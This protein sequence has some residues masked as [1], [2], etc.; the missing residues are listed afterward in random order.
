MARNRRNIRKRNKVVEL[1]TDRRFIVISSIL[2]VLILVLVGFFVISTH[3]KKAN[4]EKEQEQIKLQQQDIFELAN[5]DIDSV[6]DFESDSVIRLSVTG[7]IFCNDK[8]LQTTLI[9]ETYNFS[10]IFEDIEEYINDSNVTIGTLNTHFLD[11]KINGSNKSNSPKEFASK[12]KDSGFTMLQ[13]AQR[14]VLDYGKQGIENTNKYLT[15]DMQLDVIGTNI[16]EGTSEDRVQIKEIRNARIAFLSYTLD[17]KNIKK[18]SAQEKSMV[19]VYDE[20]KVK[21]DITYAKQNAEFCI[22]CVN[23]TDI[24]SKGVTNKQKEVVDYL[25]A[26]GANM[27]LGSNT[28]VIQT[29]EIRKND[30]EQDVFI[31][32]GLGDLIPQ[33]KDKLISLKQNK[34]TIQKLVASAEYNPSLIL[35]IQLKRSAQD[36]S[37]SLKKVDYVPV[38]MYDKGNPDNIVK[39]DRIE[40]NVETKQRSEYVGR[41]K[42]IDLKQEILSFSYDIDDNKSIVSKDINDQFIKKLNEISQQF[43]KE[44]E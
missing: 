43:K 8:L 36:G 37:V 27:I 34:K 18:K 38:N 12:L 31:S 26:Q 19:S 29:M 30:M 32:Y 42:L 33:V 35:N 1:L 20:E 15:Q 21:Q 2:L 6:K 13:L 22:V 44:S 5:Q 28:R 25:V 39:E 10:P 4:L 40:Q 9:N 17:D 14:N 24:T 23:W 3:I 11:E 41:F 7:D 16:V